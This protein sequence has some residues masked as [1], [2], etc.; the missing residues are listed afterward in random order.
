[1]FLSFRSSW[2]FYLGTFVTL[3]WFSIQG[4]SS[5][6]WPLFVFHLIF[7]YTHTSCYQVAK[8]IGQWAVAGNNSKHQF[9]PLSL[10]CA[11]ILSGH[12]GESHTRVLSALTESLLR[13][14]GIIFSLWSIRK[15]NCFK[16]LW[17]ERK[18]SNGQ[19]YGLNL[20]KLHFIWL[21]PLLFLKKRKK[22]AC[23]RKNAL[24]SFSY[25]PED[26]GCEAIKTP[27]IFVLFNSSVH[28]MDIRAPIFSRR[29]NQTAL[30]G[31]T[32]IS[33]SLFCISQLSPNWIHF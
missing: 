5:W 28:V 20:K 27:N 2:K 23:L 26:G 22:A 18:N 8:K 33:F 29:M 3:N 12:W 16:C 25:T 9:P 4:K 1:M 11:D 6:I 10:N 13:R 7:T 19:I 15:V 21:S 17:K 24:L 32:L 14:G 30:Q 31:I